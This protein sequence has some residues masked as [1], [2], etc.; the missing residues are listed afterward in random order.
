MIFPDGIQELEK[1]L[2]IHFD[3]A[4]SLEDVQKKE[5]YYILNGK[6]VIIGLKIS[7]N[8]QN[9]NF[10]ENFKS[11]IFLDLQNNYINNLTPLENL[12]ELEILDLSSNNLNNI[13]PLKNLKKL[14]RLYIQNNKITKLDALQ[15]LTKLRLLD[16]GN[17]K[18]LDIENINHKKV[19]I[20]FNDNLISKVDLDFFKL[21]IPE[22]NIDLLEYIKHYKNVLVKLQK[23]EDAA[24]VR[25]FERL[26]E[27]NIS[28]G[29]IEIN[30]DHLSLIVQIQDDFFVSNFTVAS[31][32][33]QI[34]SPP[35][36]IIT[37]G[38]D[39][40][41]RYFERISSQKNSYIYEAKVTLLGEGS[42][43]K[44]SLQRRFIKNDAALPK[45]E[46]RTRGIDVVDYDFSEYRAHIWDFGGQDVYYPVHRFFLTNDSVYLLVASTRTNIHNFDYW[47]P[48]IFQFGG[49]SPIIIIQNKFDGNPSNWDNIL[50]S[51][52][53]NQDYNI[54]KP[55]HKINLTNHNEGLNDV[56]NTLQ[57]VIKNLPLIKKEVPSSWVEVRRKL[58]EIKDEHALIPFSKLQEICNEIDKTQETKYFQKEVDIIDLAKFFNKI[59]VIHWFEKNE[60]LREYIVLKPE[61]LMSAIYSILDDSDTAQKGFINSRD[62]DRIWK[63]ET[64]KKNKIYLKSV[65]REFKI[66]FP[67]KHIKDEYILPSRTKTI[68]EN[69]KWTIADNQIRMIYEFDFMPYGIVNQLSGELSKNIFSDENIWYN[70]VDFQYENSISQV[71]E[72]RIKRKINIICKGEDARELIAIIKKAIDDI[73]SEYKGVT[74]D[75]IVPCNCKKCIS[76]NEP[77]L[78]SYIK[79]KRWIDNGNEYKHCNESDEKINLKN[80]I[81]NVGIKYDGI[82]ELGFNESETK[83]IS[84]FIFNGPVNSETIGTSLSSSKDSEKK[85]NKKPLTNDE[86]KAVSRWKRFGTYLLIIWSIIS[87]AVIVIYLKEPFLSAKEW[88]TLKKSDDFEIAKYVFLAIWTTFILKII[89]DRHLDPS[90]ENA[91]IDLNRKKYI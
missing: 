89:Y 19:F 85:E 60:I 17:N 73:I 34:L 53:S 70:A 31:A 43:G 86:K 49:S 61:W 72:D 2:K 58:S 7:A 62:F 84:T 88:E 14:K 9:I 1:K 64:Y 16:C 87:I 22:N 50:S 78:F 27:T 80:L 23:Y 3:H 67:K 59:G 38:F 30:K 29:N 82:K 8:L 71:E 55:Y 68:P 45:E 39:S 41:L 44:T 54:L 24:R 75:I 32:N 28:D 21:K 77:T 52:Y 13:V 57:T 51:F 74:Y 47:I 25:D 37:E 26:T 66:A 10:L 35:L 4:K 33:N 46:E 65:L 18:L 40:V 76:S 90:K 12:T 83:S 20:T 15:N 81:F 42:S 79:I 48:T 56:K 5:N 69:K 91:F 36:E 11:L 63:Q 6:H